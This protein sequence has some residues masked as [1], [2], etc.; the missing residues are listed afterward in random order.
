M[1][2]IVWWITSY[3]NQTFWYRENKPYGFEIYLIVLKN[4]NYLKELL[5]INSKNQSTNSWKVFALIFN[6]DITAQE[7]KKTI[8]NTNPILIKSID[9]FDLYEGDKIDQN[10]KSIAIVILNQKGDFQDKEI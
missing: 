9:F 10:Q 5:K 4:Q 7:I 6:K 1:Y 3:D 2:Y 8:K